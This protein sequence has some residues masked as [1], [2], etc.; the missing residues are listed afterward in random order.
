M[1]FIPTASQTVGPFFSIGLAP[2]YQN[3]STASASSEEKIT[4][5]GT[6]FDAD[7]LPIPDAI[8]EFWGPNEFA[9]VPTAEDGTFAVSVEMPFVGPTRA[10]HFDVLIF[11]RGLLKPVYTRVYFGTSDAIAN[12]S[13]L[14]LVPQARIATL[15]AASNGSPSQF[16][17][18]IVMQGENETVFF[19][20]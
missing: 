13:I 1:K 6:V 4:I 3:G 11:M 17:W 14:K 5:R 10:Q 8:L 19:E 9:R 12:D 7:H 18:N 15:F 2:L 20:F 16:V